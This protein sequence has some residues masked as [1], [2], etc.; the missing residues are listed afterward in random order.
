[1]LKPFAVSDDKFK[2]SS[3][4]KNNPKTCVAVAAVAEGVAVRNSTDPEKRTVY[5]SHDEWSAFLKGAKSGEF[6]VK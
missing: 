5:F 6:D 3:W 1:M 2:V 4:S